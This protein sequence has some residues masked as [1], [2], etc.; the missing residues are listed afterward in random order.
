MCAC[1]AVI[2]PN[3][4][5][6]AREFFP[7]LPLDSDPSTALMECILLIAAGVPADWLNC[8]LA[9]VL[10]GTGRQALGAMIYMITYWCIGPMLLWIFIFW[11]DLKVQG[12]WAALA[13]LANVQ[14]LFMLVRPRTCGSLQHSLPG[15]HNDVTQLSTCT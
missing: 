8:T 1:I 5:L 9:G 14:V 10:Q 11:F 13:V 12:I 3:R 2:V 7:D 4:A 15:C 6:L